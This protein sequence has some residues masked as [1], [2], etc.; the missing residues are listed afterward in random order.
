MCP[1]TTRARPLSSLHL[2]LCQLTIRIARDES[3]LCPGVPPS[4]RPGQ[5]HTYLRQFVLNVCTCRKNATVNSLKLG[6][7]KPYGQSRSIEEQSLVSWSRSLRGRLGAICPDEEEAWEGRGGPGKGAKT[8]A[9]LR[10]QSCSVDS[11]APKH[12]QKY[13]ERHTLFT[14][15]PRHRIVSSRQRPFPQLQGQQAPWVR[16]AP[17]SRHRC[18]VRCRQR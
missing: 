8:P 12:C 3:T 7:E 17:A 14:S 11:A 4:P 2:S 5:H 10:T 6:S 9:K 1:L 16:T 13:S 18:R 15:E